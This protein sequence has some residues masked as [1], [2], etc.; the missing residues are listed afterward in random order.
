MRLS[1]FL[2]DVSNS[3][4]F[5]LEGL[6]GGQPIPVRRETVVA[7]VGPA[8]RG[9]V[10]IPILIRSLSEYI[11]RFGLPDRSSPMHRQ[12]EQFFQNGGRTAIVV[13]VCQSVRFKQIEVP[14]PFGPLMLEAVNPGPLEHLRVAIDVDNVADGN[15]N[16]F[17]LVVHRLTSSDRPIVEEQEIFRGVSI[18]PED[19]RFI[20]DVLL[21]S[22]LVRVLGNPPLERPYVNALDNSFA[23]TCGEWDEAET[24]TDY[25]LIG[26][27]AAGTGIFALNQIAELDLLCLIPGTE[28]EDVGPIAHYAAERYCRKRNAIMLVDPHADWK[29]SADAIGFCEEHG[30]SSPN[31]A[32]YFPRPVSREGDTSGMSLLGAIA[33]KLAADD[34]RFGPWAGLDRDQLTLHSRCRIQLELSES[35][36]AAIARAGINVVQD[37]R[38]GYLRLSGLVTMARQPGISTVWSHLRMQR[39]ALF[40]IGSIVRGTR[41]ASLQENNVQTR[42]DLR[43]QIEAFLA[44]LYEEGALSGA[45]V[46]QASYVV[47]DK[48]INRAFS[49]RPGHISFVVGFALRD[50]EMIAFRITHRHADC[51]VREFGWHADIALAS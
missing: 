8:P 42:T 34:S 43:S 48:D 6:S 4:I 31:V 21:N 39:A 45:D 23:Y 41:W 17:N 46:E 22:R 44:A 13:R 3:G 11:Q 18:D 36:C 32:M 15:L 35:E 29:I 24:V 25:D 14:G 19:S 47:C 10:S 30:L 38:P 40:I 1:R 27:P 28:R 2:V 37:V 49:H 20:T 26:S 33:G 12:L 7:F 16:R 9:P 50:S 51:S 5:V